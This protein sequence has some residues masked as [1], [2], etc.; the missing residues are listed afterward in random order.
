MESDAA[1][2]ASREQAAADRAA[3][4]AALK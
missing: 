4:S 3:A 1:E 2:R